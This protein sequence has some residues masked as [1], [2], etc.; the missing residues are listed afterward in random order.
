MPQEL[1]DFS[2][3]WLEWRLNLMSDPLVFWPTVAAAAV[4]FVVWLWL[5][6]RFRR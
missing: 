1:M 5:T 2:R 6:R 4:L 3:W